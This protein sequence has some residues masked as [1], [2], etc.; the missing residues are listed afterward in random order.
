MCKDEDVNDTMDNIITV[1]LSCRPAAIILLTILGKQTFCRLLHLNRDIGD[2]V[3]I[4]S[5]LT[6]QIDVDEL[7]ET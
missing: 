7:F 3:K 4:L 1:S 5:E 6:K 2:S